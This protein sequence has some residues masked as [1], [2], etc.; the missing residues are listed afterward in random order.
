MRIHKFL[1]IVM[2]VALAAC[3]SPKSPAQAVYQV[4]GDYAAA[5][6]VETHYDNLPTCGTLASTPLLCKNLA[7]AK[8]VRQVDDTAYDAIEAAETAV[9]TPG[10]GT[11]KVTTA[12]ATATSAVAAFT[13]IV[14]TLGVK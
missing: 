7:T 9:R 6:S 13:N 5:L 1:A 4:K 11:D 2:L 14:A 3:V 12:L 8:M 10:Y